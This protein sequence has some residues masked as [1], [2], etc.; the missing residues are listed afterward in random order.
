MLSLEQIVNDVESVRAGLK[1]RGEEPPLD[2]VLALDSRRRDLIHEAESIRAKRNE[3]SKAIGRERRRPTDEETSEMR[4]AGRRIREIE[5]ELGSVQESLNAIL[6]A[7]PNLPEDSVPDGLEESENVLVKRRPRCFA[8]PCV[9]APLG[10]WRRAR[11]HR[12]GGRRA[13]LRRT[14]LCP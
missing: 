6:L 14:F 3:V 12:H 1:R 11:D 5:A 9:K 13:A 8:K 7:I 4:L 10:S 2:E